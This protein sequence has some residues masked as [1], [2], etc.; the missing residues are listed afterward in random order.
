MDT[1]FDIQEFEDSARQNGSRY[2]YAHEFMTRL[3]YE[4]WPSFRSVI[5][6]A[7][8]LCVRIGA[9]PTDAF[10]QVTID[11]PDGKPFHTYKLSRF[12]CLLVT[13]QADAKKPDV[14]L[15]QAALAGVAAALVERYLNTNTLDRLEKREELKLAEETLGGCAKSAGLQSADYGIFKDAGFRGMYNMSL[16]ELK[17]RKGAGNH[18]GTLYDLMGL[19]EMA[20]NTFRVTQ[21]AERLKR[22]RA[23]GL[24]HAANIAKEVGK[25]VRS[26]MVRSSG[27]RP[28][29]LPIETDL[30]EVRKGIRQTK[31]EFAKLDAPAKSAA[32]KKR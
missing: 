14:A 5:N 25:E 26:V 29:D 3:G 30:N 10:T 17:V 11:G 18:K 8:A 7:L 20:A 1:M 13:M 6:K 4:T 9:E 31:R 24:S 32:T 19:T 12:G 23:A 21:T 15:A 22:D 27:T 16:A 2:W 28:E